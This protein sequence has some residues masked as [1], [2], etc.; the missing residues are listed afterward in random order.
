[1]NV[2]GGKSFFNVGLRRVTDGAIDVTRSVEP[3]TT[4]TAGPNWTAIA[5]VAGG[6]LLLVGTI[7]F[8]VSLVLRRRRL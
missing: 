4:D 6:A 7:G 2:N 5:A 1:M 8:G 3:V